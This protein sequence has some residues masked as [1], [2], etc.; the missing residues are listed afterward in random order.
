MISFEDR[1]SAYPNRYLMTSEDGSTSYIVLERADEPIVVGT[2]MNAETFNTLASAIPDADE[3]YPTCYY[4]V[5]DDVTEWINPPMIAGVEYRTTERF[6]GKPV[7]RKLVTY[8]HSG[9]FGSETTYKDY[10]IPHGISGWAKTIRCI[11]SANDD[12]VWPYVGSAGG[13]VTAHLVDGTNITVRCYKTYWNSPT[14]Y[15]NL[16][17]IKE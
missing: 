1:V 14:I 6:D 12:G 11:T 10:T 9:Q 13:I 17:Y 8:E 3:S 7:Y 15:F 2:P 16:A 5:V 4:R